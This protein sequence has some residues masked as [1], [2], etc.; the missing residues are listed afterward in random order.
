MQEQQTTFIG[1]KVIRMGSASDYVTGRTGV[2]VEENAPKYRVHW[3]K[4]RDGS[5]LNVRTWV[6]EKFLKFIE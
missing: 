5:Q 3:Q 2:I 6:D 1:A 4:D